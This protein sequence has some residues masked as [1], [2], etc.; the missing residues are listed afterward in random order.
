M[1]I[2]KSISITKALLIACTMVAA[3]AAQAE[4]SSQTAETS[5]KIEDVKVNEVER[6]EGEV[7]TD[8]VITNRKL[9]AET[10]AK[11]KYS[12]SSSVS[13]NGGTV[14]DPLADV[15]PN[16]TAGAGTQISPRLS[17]SVGMNYRISSLQS[18]SASVGIGVDKPF[19]S[20][21]NKSFGERT[22][23]SN[24]G[25]SYSVMYK[26]AGIQNVSSVGLTA[27][28]TDYLR[29]NGYV[30]GLDLGQTAIYDFGGSN[31]SVGLSLSVSASAFDKDG[32][33][34]DQGDFSV[35]AFPFFE[36]VINDSL[37]FRTLVGFM[38]DHS[39]TEADMFTWIP[40]KVYQSAGLGISVSRD[41]YLYPNVQFIP[42]DVR[43][44]RT[45]VGISA[46]INL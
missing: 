26:A 30:A 3:N 27:F 20:D 23:V 45:N 12:F 4:E 39:R 40:N 37:N 22:S 24:P 9:R 10:G 25:V 46:N 17:A 31:V 44:D 11:K 34:L 14:E 13:Y 42:E 15:R 41:I 28:T 5:A 36:Y 19:H 38:A 43:S 33:D 16:I 32:P 2:T 6:K 29:T 35:G 8:E 1:S 18:L 21:K 7:D